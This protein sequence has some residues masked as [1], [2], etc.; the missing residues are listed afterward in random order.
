[1]KTNARNEETPVGPK[2]FGAV[3]RNNSSL[4]FAA[5]SISDHDPVPNGT[6]ATFRNA[7]QKF[8]GAQSSCDPHEC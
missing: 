4:L 7:T 5:L 1:M 6:Y 8:C 2:I 3:V